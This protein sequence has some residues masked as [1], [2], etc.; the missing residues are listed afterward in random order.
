MRSSIFWDCY[1]QYIGSELLL[2]RNNLSF[3][4]S[5]VNLDCLTLEDWRD[6]LSQKVCNLLPIY[7]GQ[8]IEK[9]Q[10][11]SIMVV[12]IE[13]SKHKYLKFIKMENYKLS[14]GSAL[15]MKVS[16]ITAGSS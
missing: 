9:W 3:L 13:I 14:I 4:S 8:I 10:P 1:V 12:I 11:Y 15:N 16:N 6:S 5:K 2:F 7:T